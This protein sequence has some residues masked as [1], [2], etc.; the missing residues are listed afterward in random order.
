METPETAESS[1]DSGGSCPGEALKFGS[2]AITGLVGGL[3]LSRV[4]AGFVRMSLPSIVPVVFY[5]VLRKP[6]G[7]RKVLSERTV[8]EGFQDSPLAGAE[9][10][11]PFAPKVSGDAE[12][13]FNTGG[14]T[15]FPVFLDQEPID[16]LSVDGNVDPG[17]FP[18]IEAGREIAVRTGHS[19]LSSEEWAASVLD[20]IE[21]S[22]SFTSQCDGQVIPGPEEQIK[23]TEGRLDEDTTVLSDLDPAA[24]RSGVEQV[25]DSGETPP[26]R[27]SDVGLD[28]EEAGI[29]R[30]ENHFDPSPVEMDREIPAQM[31]TDSKPVRS[32]GEDVGFRVTP[33]ASGEKEK[34][35][36]RRI[37]MDANLVPLAVAKVGGKMHRLAEEEGHDA[38]AVPFSGCAVAGVEAVENP[39]AR[40]ENADGGRDNTGALASVLL[41]DK[42]KLGKR[43]GSE[44]PV[45]RR[46]CIFFIIGIVLGC[47]VLLAWKALRGTGEDVPEQALM[48]TPEAIEAPGRGLSLLGDN[49][50]SGEVHDFP[51]DVGV[52][53]STSSEKVI[54][55]ED[56]PSFRSLE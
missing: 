21:G 10:P 46:V 8:G 16:P 52:T 51:A 27:Q 28:L 40:E 43:G 41:Q 11:E 6:A 25:T 7:S 5:Q 44:N 26:A 22:L 20:E 42:S 47:G 14:Q 19:S 49:A 35:S 48:I 9:T 53:N 36:Y 56:L 30:I 38:F 15:G 34:P 32:A 2:L 17:P 55:D 33:R 18:S 4:I 24:W 39:F 37:P 29:E 23:L 54:H 50:S 13:D 3:I 1:K 31:V 45:F 12:P